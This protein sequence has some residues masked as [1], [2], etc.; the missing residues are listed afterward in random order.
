MKKGLGWNGRRRQE[1]EEEKAGGQG[2]RELWEG[3]VRSPSKQR[4]GNKKL[5]RENV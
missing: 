5:T 1:E 3:K 4:N 2:I